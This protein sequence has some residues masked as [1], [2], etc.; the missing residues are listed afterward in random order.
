MTNYP[1]T[2]TYSEWRDG[3]V[4]ETD[5]VL[6]DALEVLEF[7]VR[8]MFKDEHLGYRFKDADGKVLKFEMSG[9]FVI[10]K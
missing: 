4:V 5:V 1:V 9:M 3:S 6:H 2:L 8:R 7:V 10:D